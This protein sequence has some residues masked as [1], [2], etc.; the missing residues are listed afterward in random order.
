MRPNQPRQKC[1]CGLTFRYDAD[2]QEH[3]RVGCV[4]ESGK[5][6]SLSADPDTAGSPEVAEEDAEL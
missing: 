2:F 4:V 6:E 3:K 5:G 1:E